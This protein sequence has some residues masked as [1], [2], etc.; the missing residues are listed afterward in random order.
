MEQAANAACAK[1]KADSLLNVL[2]ASKLLQ[3]CG[4]LLPVPTMLVCLDGDI[5]IDI[6][7]FGL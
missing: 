1:L 6:C 3:E 4:R 2:S 5:D 7:G